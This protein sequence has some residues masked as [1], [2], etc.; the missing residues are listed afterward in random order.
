VDVLNERYAPAGFSF[1]LIDIFD[2]DNSSWR[3]VKYRSQQEYQMKSQLRQGGYRDLN[4]Y[5]DTI[6]PLPNGVE[7]F[8]YA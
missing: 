4:L 1:N 6:A 2:I 7:L 8:G 3:Q 5:L